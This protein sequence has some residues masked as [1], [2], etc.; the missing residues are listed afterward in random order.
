MISFRFSLI[1]LLHLFV[2][3]NV[4]NSQ[5][6]LTLKYPEKT[7]S[8]IVEIS[9]EDIG[10]DFDKVTI[11]SSDEKRPVKKADFSSEGKI[12]FLD[13]QLAKGEN[14]FVVIAYKNG[15]Y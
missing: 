10:G 13:V 6:S 5:N 7:R 12:Y 2:F 11:T 8:E 3:C 9:L 4:A 1:A 15:R 14:E